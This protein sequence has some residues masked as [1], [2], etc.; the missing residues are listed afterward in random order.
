MASFPNPSGGLNREC[1]DGF[2][3]QPSCLAV[4]VL[5]CLAVMVLAIAAF[6]IINLF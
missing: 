6:T 4:M 1:Y 5:A 3:N 2:A